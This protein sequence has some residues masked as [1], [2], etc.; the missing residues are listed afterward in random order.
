MT[1]TLLSLS[2][3]RLPLRTLSA[4][5]HQL[6]IYLARFRNRLS[7]VHA[8]H[9]RRLA[10]VLE[11]L[12]KY[13]EEWRD[14]G[15]QAQAQGDGGTVKAEAKAKGR[16]GPEVEVM[17]SGELMA[18]LGRKAEGVNLLEIEKYLRESKVRHQR[19]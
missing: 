4:A 17:T 11:A 16:A 14:G 19:L 7:T 3:T 1:S 8:L 9:L 15:G 6:S 18:R 5:R 12:A 2:T 13:A 10:N